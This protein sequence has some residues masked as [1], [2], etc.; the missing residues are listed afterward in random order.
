MCKSEN[1]KQTLSFHCAQHVKGMR[2]SRALLTAHRRFH[3]LSGLEASVTSTATQLLSQRL[4]PLWVLW[5]S[6]HL[7]GHLSVALLSFWLPRRRKKESQQN[8]T[9]LYIS[10]QMRPRRPVGAIWAGVQSCHPSPPTEDPIVSEK[11]AL[12]HPPHNW[13]LKV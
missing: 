7:A 11:P 4:P 10:V 9:L 1:V 2:T 13:R 3:L 12:S 6:R 5:T 8:P